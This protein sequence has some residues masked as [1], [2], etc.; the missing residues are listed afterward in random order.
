MSFFVRLL[1]VAVVLVLVACGEENAGSVPDHDGNDDPFGEGGGDYADPEHCGGSGVSGASGAS[2]GSGCVIGGDGDGESD[3]GT[4]PVC[5]LTHTFTYSGAATS[6][7]VSGSFLNPPWPATELEGALPLE[8]TAPGTWSLT[9]T[10]A[11]AGTYRYKLIID[12]TQWIIDPANPDTEMDA[13]G[14]VNSLV[15]VCVVDLGPVNCA[16]DEFS[17]EDPVM[18]FAMTDRFY[19]ADGQA[20]PVAGAE[21]G[22]AGTGPSAQYEGGDFK[23]VTAKMSYLADLGVTAL[24]LSAPYNNRET[25]GAAINPVADPRLYSGYHGYWP[26]PA[27]ISYANPAAPAP[28]PA[29]ESR[30]GTS[31]D[32]KALIAAAHAASSADGGGIKVLFDYVMKHVDTESGLYAAHPDWFYYEDGE[33]PL[34]GWKYADCNSRTRVDENAQGCQGWDHAYYST[35]CAFTPYLAGFDFHEKQE[36]I[37]WSVN[38]ALWWAREYQL[39]GYRLDAIKHV[40]L[41]WL[42]QLRSRLRADFA[43]P[44][45]GRFYLVG[46]T[47]DYGNRDKLKQFVDPDT[48]LDGQFD[49]PFKLHLCNALFRPEGD[50]AAFA[51]WMAGND[52]YYGPGAVMS[53]WIG[54]HDIPRAIHFASGQITSCYQ[55]SDVGNGWA[56]AS[57][58]QPAEAEPYE[59]LGVAFAI[60]M[61]NRGIPLIYYGDEV[62]LAGGGDPDDRRMMPWNDGGLNPHQIALR[63]Q[64]R[65]LSRVRAENPIL[66]RGTRTTL[67]SSKNTWVYEMGG[68]D[69]VAPITVAINRADAV[70]SVTLPKPMYENLL[71]GGQQAGGQVSLPARSFLVLR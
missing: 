64:V 1:R 44:I 5:P 12:G 69:E 43:D 13:S 37:D 52:G 41:S 28:R 67:S 4:E 65:A 29:V 20:S 14:N 15:R 35:R 59:R 23:G 51:T 45:G 25:P 10:F 71:E 48:M 58:P 63:Q 18:Y 7:W 61:T 53:T 26:S 22:N 31:N 34:C 16:L 46:E 49:F 24:W 32:L 47:F 40:P 66:G 70:E 39:D 60:M 56:G 11:S 9:H 54:N 3:A 57:Y 42:T 17:W 8:Q 30:L 36:A 2:G 55:G 27:N 6:V 19:N 50:L 21:D 62:G 38:D 33:F 68:C